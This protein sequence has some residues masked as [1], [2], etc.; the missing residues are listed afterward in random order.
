MEEQPP[1]Q[2]QEV[3]VVTHYWRDLEVAG[4]HLSAPLDAGDRIH[5]LGHTSDFDQCVGSMEE[6]HHQVLHAGAGEDVGVK[7]VE[8]A[9][10]HDKIYKLVPLE[11]GSEGSEL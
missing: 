11:A 10:E 5:V 3:G 4:V 2:E 8:H 9:R 7:M 6:E 1:M